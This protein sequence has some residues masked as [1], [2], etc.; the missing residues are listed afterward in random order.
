MSIF[1]MIDLKD[2]KF[3]LGIEL[4]YIFIFCNKG[5]L[6]RDGIFYKLIGW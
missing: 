2:V 6:I 3:Y 5:K 1:K 4:K